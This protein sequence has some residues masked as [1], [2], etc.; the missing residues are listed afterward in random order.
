MIARSVSSL[1]SGV[2]LEINHSWAGSSGL[3]YTSAACHRQ[4][5]LR[6]IGRSMFHVDGRPISNEDIVPKG[7]GC[8]TNSIQQ[9]SHAINVDGNMLTLS[10]PT[11]NL[12][13]SLF[14][15][16]CIVI[17]QAAVPPTDVECDVEWGGELAYR[18][19]RCLL[20]ITL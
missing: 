10:Y 11:S 15:S 18:W 17:S 2:L 9:S 14:D 20:N 19:I 5:Q 12:T 16:G 6:G 3:L 13:R 4:P 1:L 7:G 8:E